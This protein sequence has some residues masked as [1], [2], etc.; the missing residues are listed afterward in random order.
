MKA[1]IM[2]IKMHDQ[3]DK[4]IYVEKLQDFKSQKR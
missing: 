3:K 4:P 1:N 2:S